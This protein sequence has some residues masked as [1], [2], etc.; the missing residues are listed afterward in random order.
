MDRRGRIFGSPSPLA[1]AGA[2]SA[3]PLARFNPPRSILIGIALGFDK[4]LGGR[5][6]Y[7]NDPALDSTSERRNASHASLR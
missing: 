1:M 4:Y 6:C 7:I 2:L 3:V 5:S